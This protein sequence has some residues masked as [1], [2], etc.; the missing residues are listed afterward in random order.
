MSVHPVTILCPI[1]F[2]CNLNSIGFEIAFSNVEFGGVI[3]ESELMSLLHSCGRYPSET[4]LKEAKRKAFSGTALSCW[5]L[6]S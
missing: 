6:V 3:Q 1:Q 4:E 2:V 5:L